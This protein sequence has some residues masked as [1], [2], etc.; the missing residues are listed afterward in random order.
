MS[1]QAIHLILLL[2]CD[3]RSHKCLTTE[4]VAL[5]LILALLFICHCMMSIN[6]LTL[7]LYV[8]AM[9]K[10]NTGNIIYKC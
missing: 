3:L 1:L 4:N 6:I 7:H 5:I 2:Y 10:I 8:T 9:L